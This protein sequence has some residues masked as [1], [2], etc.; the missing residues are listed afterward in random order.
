MSLSACNQMVLLKVLVAWYRRTGRLDL[1]SATMNMLAA[2][3]VQDS[4]VIQT[5]LTRFRK[6][7][8]FWTR[9]GDVD[10]EY[11]TCAFCVCR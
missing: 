5:A 1:P 2:S 4:R 8:D 9:M 11:V 3:M 10:A 7:D 6:T